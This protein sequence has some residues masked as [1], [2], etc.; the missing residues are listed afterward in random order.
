MKAKTWKILLLIVLIAG[1]ILLT[2][3]IVKAVKSD[4]TDGST[5]AT[6]PSNKLL[7]SLTTTAFAATKKLYANVDVN[8]RKAPSI[9]G[10]KVQ[11]VTAGTFIGTTTG[12]ESTADNNTWVEVT[13]AD[14]TKAYVAKN[15]TYILP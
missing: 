10:E 5:S 9:T 13:L 7:G 8:V 11:A 6:D 3:Q 12:T 2:T 1:A 14:G 15:Y 4:K